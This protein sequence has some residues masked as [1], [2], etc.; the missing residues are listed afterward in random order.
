MRLWMLSGDGAEDCCDRVK[1]SD[2]AGKKV[3]FEVRTKLKYLFVV[4]FPGV[5][6]K[7]QRGKSDLVLVPR[8]LTFNNNCVVGE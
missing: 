6:P 3:C 8:P 5:K 2:W 1:E 4:S 7:I